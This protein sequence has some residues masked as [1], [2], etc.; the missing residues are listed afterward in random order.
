MRE[1]G[2]STGGVPEGDERRSQ[3]TKVACHLFHRL[4]MT[5]D[6]E[7]RGEE[8]RRERGR[9]GEGG[10]GGGGG[11]GVGSGSGEREGAR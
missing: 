1:G 6:L 2:R 7:R 11:G 3:G 4:P 9:E 10:G 5:D 8:G